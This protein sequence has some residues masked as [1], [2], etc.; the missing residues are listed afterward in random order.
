MGLSNMILRLAG[1]KVTYTVPDFAKCIICVAPHTSNWDFIMAEL[2]VH[3]VGRRA[4][5]L[6]KASWFR[7][8]LGYFF[9]SIGGI[10]VARKNKK[11]SLTEVLV[12]KFQ[13]SQRLVVAIAPEGTRKATTQWHKGFLYIARDAGVPLVLGAIDYGRKQ[14]VV[15]KVYELTGDVDRDLQNIKKYY[16]QFN[17]LYPDKFIAD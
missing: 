15:E 8:P 2:A 12:R 10:A 7:W 5:F 13:E 14:I 4:G 16:S 17:G 6:M 3:S 1:W 11:E 9:R